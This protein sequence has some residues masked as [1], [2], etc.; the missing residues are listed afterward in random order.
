[1]DYKQELKLNTRTERREAA[2]D[3]TGM[4]N[5]SGGLLIY[6]VEENELPDGRVV[7]KGPTP[8]TD[9]SLRDKLEDILDSTVSPRLRLEAAPIDTEEGFFLLVRVHERA[10][11]LHMLEGY[12]EH[13]YY[14]RRGRRVL[15]MTEREV[16][17]AYE[18]LQAAQSGLVNLVNQTPL[19]PRLAPI[20]QRGFDEADAGRA[21]Q[22]LSPWLGVVTAPMNAVQ[23]VI[24]IRYADQNAF[25]EPSAMPRLGSEQIVANEGFRVDR[26]GYFYEVPHQTHHPP[27]KWR[28][29]LY[30]NGVLEWGVP[31][32]AFHPGRAGFRGGRLSSLCTTRSPTSAPC[33]SGRVTT[34]RSA[35]GSASI[36][37]KERTSRVLA[38]WHEPTNAGPIQEPADLAFRMDTTADYLASGPTAGPAFLVQQAMDYFWQA[39]GWPRCPYFSDDRSY[40]PR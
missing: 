6:G 7:P 1:M 33:T 5:A 34:E 16:T 30:R 18:Q 9:H 26:D 20:R 31:S 29:R 38:P 23:P 3:A 24:E 32:R 37:P 12:D 10:G 35:R 8:L 19:L 17:Q 15:P 39:Y 27:F 28:L 14:A 36:T 2:R 22:Q 13:R 40:T 4:A 21:N 25:P 11:P